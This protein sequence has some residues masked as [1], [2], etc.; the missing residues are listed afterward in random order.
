[1]TRV[2]GGCLA[3]LC[4][5]AT[6]AA[7]APAVA[8]P[9][10]QPPGHTLTVTLGGSGTGSVSSGDGAIACPPTCTHFYMAPGPVTLTE[11]PASG[12]T[13]TGWSGTCGTAP[14]CTVSMASDHTVTATFTGGSSMPPPA[15][16]C[17]ARLASDHVLLRASSS[18]PARLKKV[19]KLFFSFGC[20]QSVNVTL[21]VKVTEFVPGKHHHRVT[22]HLVRHYILAAHHTDSVAV[23][24]WGAALRGL[25]RHVR[26]MLAVSVSATN[27]NGGSAWAATAPLTGVG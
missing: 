7:I 15:P 8:A 5:A 22:F 26:E 17:T 24:L 9:P 25:R 27:D 4:L 3:V 18:R 6:S 2:V 10:P 12:S 20:N 14:T 19:G 11:T 1:M 13:F 23:K 16:K 21:T